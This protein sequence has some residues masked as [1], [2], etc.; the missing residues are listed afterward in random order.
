VNLVNSL[1]WKMMDKAIFS[2]SP[3]YF[4]IKEKNDTCFFVYRTGRRILT[5]EIGELIWQA[6]PDS[7][8]G[9][10]C[11]VREQKYIS[12]RLLK[13]YLFILSKAGIILVDERHNLDYIYENKDKQ[14]AENWRSRSDIPSNWPATININNINEAPLS[15]SEETSEEDN[16]TKPLLSVIVVTY[17]GEEYIRRCLQSVFQQSYFIVDN[18]SEDATVDIVQ[19][20]FP[21][22]R[23]IKLKQNRHY[24]GGLNQGIKVSRGEY[25]MFLNQDVFLA[26]DCLEAL[27]VRLKSEPEAG[28]A[29]PMIK[30]ANLP[31]FINGLGNQVNNRGWGTDNF[32]YCLDIGQFKSL[33]ELPS[34]CFGAA[35]VARKAIEKVGLLDE[36][37]GSFYED[38]DWSFRCWFKGW[39]VIPVPEAV[40][41]HEFGASYAAGKKLFFVVRNRLRLVLKLFQG[42]IRLGFLKNYLLE[43]G[44]NILSLLRRKELRQVLFYLAAYVSL[45]FQLPGIFVKRWRVMSGKIK[46]MREQVVLM[47]NPSFYCCL[48][49]QE[50]MP[51][52]T[53]PVIRRYYRWCQKRG[54]AIEGSGIS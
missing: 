40:V 3:E 12:S 4:F 21:Q 23:L 36:G 31:A 46:G 10:L 45:G 32:I 24:A 44:R 15:N 19:R 8:E 42:R 35:F 27:Y 29:A 47:K 13:I 25:L 33:Q 37:Y 6:L 54:E 39:R 51:E 22:C 53:V 11:K 52:I 49:P 26:P 16:Q 20:Y 5:D 38:V 18:A 30:F 34:A 9:V 17:N 28:L 7:L 50:A 48:H 1:T 41:Y 14:R 2:K 43:D